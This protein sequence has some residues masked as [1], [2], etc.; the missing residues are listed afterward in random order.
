MRR[1]PRQS[2]ARPGPA[3]PSASASSRSSSTS[4]ATGPRPALSSLTRWAARSRACSA[5]GTSISDAS[6]AT[7]AS[8]VTRVDNPGSGPSP[9]ARPSAAPGLVSTCRNPPCTARRTR[10]PSACSTF[11]SQCTTSP[12]RGV[13]PSRTVRAP[14]EVASTTEVAPPAKRDC[15]GVTISTPKTSSATTPP[16]PRASSPSRARTPRRRR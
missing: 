11:T 12:T 5:R 2:A 6:S 14:S 8:T 10:V 16:R 4:S 1:R 15:S 7:P 3:Q 9:S 13:W